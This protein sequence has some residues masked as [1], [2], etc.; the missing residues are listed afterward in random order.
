VDTT[1]AVVVGDWLAGDESHAAMER[2]RSGIGR[3]R[4]RE[5]LPAAVLADYSEEQISANPAAAIPGFNTDKMYV[6]LVW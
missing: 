1:S 5:D 6:G 4:D 3:E 2:L